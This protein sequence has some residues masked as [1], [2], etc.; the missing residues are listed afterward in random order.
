MTICRVSLVDLRALL[1][2]VAVF[3]N[4]PSCQRV[5]TCNSAAQ[6]EGVTTSLAHFMRREWHSSDWLSAAQAYGSLANPT[7]RAFQPQRECTD[8]RHVTPKRQ[9][10]TAP[11]TTQHGFVGSLLQTR[12]NNTNRQLPKY[13]TKASSP[14]LSMASH[15]LFLFMASPRNLHKRDQTII[16]K[17]LLL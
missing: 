2:N 9:E 1:S 5:E 15:M 16:L 3:E 14:T 17:Q 6:F 10:S 13:L 4:L 12:R 7:N 11:I 8:R